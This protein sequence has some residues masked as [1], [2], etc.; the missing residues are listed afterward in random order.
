[1]VNVGG[2]YS[3][4]YERKKE[5]YMRDE[6]PAEEALPDFLTTALQV[7]QPWSIQLFIPSFYHICTMYVHI[8][9]YIIYVYIH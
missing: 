5:M 7:T 8:E 1:M 9:M 2:T 3:L 4:Q 6:R